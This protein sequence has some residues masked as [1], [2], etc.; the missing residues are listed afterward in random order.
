[1]SCIPIRWFFFFCHFCYHILAEH[2]LFYKLLILIPPSCWKLSWFVLFLLSLISTTFMF[3]N[4]DFVFFTSFLV[5]QYVQRI[6]KQFLLY[7]Y[8]IGLGILSSVGL[9]T[10]LHTFLLYLVRITFHKWNWKRLFSL[11]LSFQ[12]LKFWD[13]YLI[14]SVFYMNSNPQGVI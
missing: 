13:F 6:E 8:W 7:A 5:F 12:R 14:T 11:V 9:G 10:G 4:S 1:M 2:G 3:K